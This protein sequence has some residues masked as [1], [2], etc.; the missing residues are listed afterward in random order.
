MSEAV[1]I[2][3]YSTH[4]RAGAGDAA[5]VAVVQ[6]LRLGLRLGSPLRCRA[7]AALVVV[8]PAAASMTPVYSF[9]TTTQ[10]R[11]VQLNY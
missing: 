4:L 1:F 3:K 8:L 5:H 6:L 10:N 7:Y 9:N 2:S 11:V